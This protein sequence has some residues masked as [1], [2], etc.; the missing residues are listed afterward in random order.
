MNTVAYVTVDVFTSERFVGNPLAVIPDARGLSSE[1]MQKI[2]A[3]FGYSETTFVLPPE[4]PDHTA[5]VRIFTPTAEIPFAGHPNVGTAF[6]LGQQQGI[7]GKPTGDRLT[8]EED[9]GLVEVTLLRTDGAV[10]STS[11][12]APASLTIGETIADD[13]IARCVQIDPRSIRKT[14]HAP[15]FA[16]VGLPFAFA[17]LDSLEALGKARPNAAV[18]AEAAARHK[19]DKTGFSLFLYLRSAENPWQIRARMFAPLDNVTEDPATGS[20]S[21]ALGAYLT[22]LLPARDA[23]VKITIEQGV[24]MGRRSLIGVEVKKTAGTVNE[25][26]LSGSSVRVM[27]GEVLL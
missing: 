5:R 25:V 22:S 11:I 14:T 15:T 18:F 27:R 2:A 17:E 3:E 10:T 6:V 23:D 21:A 8:F 24:E 12:R 19:E 1:A 9:A 20:A 4:K 7:F 13:L 26:L 16:S